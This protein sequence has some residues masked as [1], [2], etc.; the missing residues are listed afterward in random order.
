[1]ETNLTQQSLALSGNKDTVLALLVHVMARDHRGRAKG[2]SAEHLAQK[3][4]TSERM[5]RDLVSRARE[6]GTA[7]V[8]TPESGYYVAQTAEEL[9][10]CCV[11]LRGRAMHS[12][13]I[14][15]RL[16]KISLPQLMG[17]L[18]LRT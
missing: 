7:I 15:A 17:Q 4:G 16:R 2:I 13:M 1:M 10:E 8:A 18:N 3:I 5:L 14:E 9:E 11:F 6:E 12:L